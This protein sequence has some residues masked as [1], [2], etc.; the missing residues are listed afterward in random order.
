VFYEFYHI[1]IWQRKTKLNFFHILL[2]ADPKKTEHLHAL[3]GSAE[4]LH[5]FKA[6]LLEEGSFDA[7]VDGCECVFHTASPFYNNPKD[8]QVCIDFSSSCSVT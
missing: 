7:V 4:R 3:D 2:S 5:L 1:Y 8:P 6:D